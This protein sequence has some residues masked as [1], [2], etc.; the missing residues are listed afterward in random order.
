MLRTHTHT[1]IDFQKGF[2]LV[3]KIFSEKIF[4]ICMFALQL[5]TQQHFQ[6]QK[7]ITYV[8]MCMLYIK[9]K[10]K[11]ALYRIKRNKCAGYMCAACIKK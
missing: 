7:G 1:T 3:S 5:R 10:Y 8:C 6:L 4:I 11:Q 2:H 9:I